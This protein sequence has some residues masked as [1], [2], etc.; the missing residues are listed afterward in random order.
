MTQVKLAA[1]LGI[2]KQ[3]LA[4]HIKGGKAPSIDDIDA[5]HDF[6]AEVGREGSAPPDL[7]RKIA[8]QRLRL[9]KEN[10][11]RAAIENAK[12]RGETIDK[13]EM[14][15]FMSELVANCFQAE[16]RRMTQEYPAMLKGKTEIEIEQECEKREQEIGKKMLAIIENT[17]SV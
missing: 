6:L 16:L 7:K 9:V 10:A 3:N 2:S 8:E 4:F 11:D 1:I 13:A 17:K 14:Q 12:R 5:W 15:R